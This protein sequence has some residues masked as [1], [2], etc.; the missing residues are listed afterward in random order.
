MAA[1]A[2]ND[3]ARSPGPFIR[4]AKDAVGYERE[5]VAGQ[6]ALVPWFAE[7]AKLGNN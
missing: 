5:L 2:S 3:S 1:Y 4:R 6:W 7:T